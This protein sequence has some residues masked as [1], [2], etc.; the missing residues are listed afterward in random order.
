M[1]YSYNGTLNNNENEWT[2][3]SHNVHEWYKHI[4]EQKKPQSVCNIILVIPISK[5]G[6][7]IY[8]VRH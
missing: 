8:G 5:S 3:I 7:I 1:T 4:V 2:M 6:K